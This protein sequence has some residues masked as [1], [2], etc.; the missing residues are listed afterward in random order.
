[1]SFA[2][3][4]IP[5]NSAGGGLIISNPTT[6]NNVTNVDC[7][8]SNGNYV[9]P[10]TGLSDGNYYYDDNNG[11]YYLYKDGVLRRFNYNMAI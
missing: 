2:S 1:M 11:L 4:L 3:Y 8:D 10:S 5:Y 9:G 6:I 7:W